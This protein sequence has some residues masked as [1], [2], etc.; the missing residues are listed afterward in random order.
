[1]AL[2]TQSVNGWIAAMLKYSQR[3]CLYH[4]RLVAPGMARSGT[5]QRELSA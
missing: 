3:T 5:A 2:K 4:G 1:M